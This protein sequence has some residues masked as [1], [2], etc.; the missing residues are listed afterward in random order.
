MATTWR[1]AQRVEA[2]AAAVRSGRRSVRPRASSATVPPL[3]MNGD[4][5]SADE[6]EQGGRHERRERRRAGHQRGED[7]R[8]DVAR[9]RRAA[10]RS[11]LVSS[12]SATRKAPPTIGTAS[13]SLSAG[14]GDEADDDERPVRGGDQRAA[15][16]GGLQPGSVRHR[17]TSHY[18]SCI[19]PKRWSRRRLERRDARR[20]VSVTRVFAGGCAVAAF[21]V[22]VGARGRGRRASGPSRRRRGRARRARTFARRSS[23]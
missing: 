1:A 4:H 22:L 15:L 19:L 6:D 9:R 20:R 18:T 16:Q 10:A 8:D 23:R 7:R 12:S 14:V 13:S 17:Q 21:V 11:A 3:T 2:A 5:R